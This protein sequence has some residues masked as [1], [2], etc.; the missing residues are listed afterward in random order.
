MSIKDRPYVGTWELRSRTLVRHTPDAIVLINGYAEFA[1]CATCNRKL[2]LQ[3][4]V[5]QV[6]CDAT[7]DGIATA[8]VTLSIP[9][10]SADVFGTDGNYILQP[11]L[12]VVILMRGYFPMRGFGGRGQEESEGGFSADNVPM[13]PYYQVFRGV[14]TNVAHGYSGGFYTA[15]LTCANLL[16]FWQHL[17]LSVNG[18]V[19][20][21][22]PLGSMVE[23]SLV[24]HKF[25]SMNP[26]AIIYTLVKVGFGAAYGVDFQF[27]QA[28][29]ISANDGSDRRSLYV[30]AAEWWEKR[31]TEHSG[32]L[33]MYGIDGTLFNAMQQA[34]LGS[35][36][37]TRKKAAKGGGAFYE[38]AKQLYAANSDSNDF[39][40]NRSAEAL[41]RARVLGYNPY[42]T[43]AAVY[44]SQSRNR[45]GEAIS[46]SP[47]FY[48][49]N[50]LK[51]QAFALDIGKMGSVNLFETEYL[52]KYEIAKQVT[53]VTGYEFYQDVD[54]DLVFK[55]PMYNMD[56]RS[57]PVYRIEDRDLIS[58]DETETEP[59]ATLM[60]GTGSHF[61]NLTGHGVD[62][63]AGVGGVY[64]DYR[65]VAKYGYREETFETNY[66]TSRHAIFL[67]AI[68]RLDLAN[69]GVKS[70]SITIPL[71]PEIKPGYPVYVVSQDCFYYVKSLSHSFSPG[72]SCTTTIEGVAKRTKWF[73]PMETPG[74][75]ELPSLS[76]VRLDAPGEYPPAPL[77]GF[78]GRG[79]ES[80]GGLLRAYGFP[81]VVLA[82]D[83]RPENINFDTVDLDRSTLSPEGY[84]QIAL[85]TGALE[86]GPEEDTF[87]LRS[88]N[89]GGQVIDLASLK[90]EWSEVQ[91]ALQA[92]TFEQEP[93]SELGKVI[94]AI[95]ERTGGVDTPAVR[96]LINYLSLQTSLK[97]SFS[98]GSTIA[99]KYRYFSC[100][101]PDPKHQAPSSLYVDQEN[102]K[103]S[104]RKP[105]KPE[106]GY[107]QKI[108]I[109][110][111]S[112]SGRGIEIVPDEIQA[113][114]AISTFSQASD[115]NAP[116]Y[117]L[118]VVSTADIRFVN[119]GPQ[120]TRKQYRVSYVD[121]GKKQGWNFRLN[122]GE[123]KK[124][125]AVLLRTN[126]LTDL[127]LSITDRFGPE[128]ERL[129]RATGTFS[130]RVGAAGKSSVIRAASQVATVG[131]AL[132]RLKNLTEEDAEKTTAQLY[133]TKDEEERVS[134]LSTLLASALWTYV[135]ALIESVV[136]GIRPEN[137]E[138]FM[139]ARSD[140]LADYT[141]GE[142]LVPDN[143]PAKVYFF[144]D[145]F[146]EIADWT[147]IFPVSDAG[148]Y[149]VYGN[150]PYGRG[151]TI[152]KYADLIQ[153]ETV[154][155]PE[156]D[157][158]EAAQESEVRVG[159]TG[160]NASTLQLQEKFWAAY[161]LAGEDAERALGALSEPERRAFLAA[162]NTT[163]DRV[164]Q[165]VETLLKSDTSENAKVRNYPVT[166][167]F[168]GQSILGDA[169]AKNLANLSLG[170]EVCAC[171]GVDQSVLLQAFTEEFLSLNSEDPVQSFLEQEAFTQGEAYKRTKEVLAG[172]QLQRTNRRED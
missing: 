43:T 103:V 59:E 156:G 116:V 134:N 162:Y 28:T 95:E 118:E 126:S 44:G 37:D 121:S 166:S 8:N 70:A 62:G 9:K 71:R 27:S 172:T 1:S 39:D 25:T 82:L 137:Y 31:W 96:Q 30:H 119:F 60:K 58:I 6:S 148:G 154:G 127:G 169:A 3:R 80:G 36:Y 10:H 132:S 92:G 40:P 141:D 26:Y 133:P 111:D 139:K 50:I 146:N 47:K 73:P 75:G 168:R 113:G 157:P 108:G 151:V 152:E 67:S 56:T 155:D 46:G 164:Q 76:H 57:D 101:H 69:A 65:L 128:Y 170:G 53:T 145:E 117:E 49:E 171:R 99:G 125:F 72:S 11:S 89:N 33:R 104:S 160:S 122:A 22:R 52:S 2:N 19:F 98:P 74:P 23:P 114:I 135:S 81:N 63:W 83:A 153:A 68:N 79:A 78:E 93:N 14:V 29:N 55:P 61:A 18:S 142:A 12:E 35:W 163:E 150:L 131:R 84:I 105:G 87:I 112:S 115:P 123:T 147:P 85:A 32:S 110:R 15:T 77:Y 161:L 20:G 120:F 149:E 106:A 100:S 7:T 13:Y 45:S 24:G 109:L 54:G 158:T 165:T 140:F 51:M 107:T 90:R 102:G 41:E 136:G 143:D 144:S 97:S 130:E 124:A 86:R 88:S 167:Y 17:H 4:Y 159:A 94:Q 64:I 91:E 42:Q 21:K 138:A 66:L 16:H 5:T 34:W 48:S 38:T 129:F